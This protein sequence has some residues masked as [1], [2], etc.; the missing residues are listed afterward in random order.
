MENIYNSLSVSCRT[1][2]TC[3]V[4]FKLEYKYK[5]PTCLKKYCGV[6]CFKK[7]RKAGC[8]RKDLITAQECKKEEASSSQ[9]EEY[10]FETEDTVPLE[11]LRL[12]ACD[13]ELRN[14]LANPHLKDILLVL[15]TSSDPEKLIDDA[16]KEP[17]FIEF[18]NS[19]LQLVESKGGNQT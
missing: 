1:P 15:D 19:C 14:Q 17:I 3:E 8:Q 11:K 16:M 7:H 5:C 12:L 9:K 10:V 18:A 2:K 6:E 4:C 13:Q